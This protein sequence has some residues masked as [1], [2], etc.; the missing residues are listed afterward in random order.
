MSIMS[1]GSFP[2]ALQLGVNKWFGRYML[3]N[4]EYTELFEVKNSEKNFEIDVGMVGM[5][6][7]A[8]IPEGMDPLYDASNQGGTQRYVHTDYGLGFVITRNAIADN[9]YMDL[10][11][12]NVKNL[13]DSMLQTKETVAW[14]LLNNGFTS[15]YTCYD[16]QPIY[17][18]AH[19]NYKGGT[20]SNVLATPADLSEDAIEQMIIQTDKLENDAGLRMNARLEK[21]FVPVESRFI[22]ERIL[23]SVLRPGTSGAT[24]PN[25][26]N[27][28]RSLGMIPGGVYCCHYL[29]DSDA[30]FGKTSVDNGFRIFQ[31]RDIAI[32]NDTEFNSQNI[33]YVIDERYSVGITDP[34]ATIGTPGA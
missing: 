17:S 3:L 12:A 13:S 21:L 6:L 8:A 33:R 26:V 23:G 14:N 27:A 10:A 24:N 30:F 34:R 29:T 4:K 31:R 22:A 15:A 25:D 28:L 11:E 2:Q 7:A 32:R 18:N 9:L 16:N 19:L 5:G 1:T 20:F